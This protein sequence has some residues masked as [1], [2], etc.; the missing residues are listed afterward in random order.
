MEISPEK[1]EK[2][3]FLGQDAVRCK[4]IV[5]NKYLQVKILNISIVKFP[6]KMKNTFNKN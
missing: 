3:A 2:M 4:I 5:D 6:M 1:Y